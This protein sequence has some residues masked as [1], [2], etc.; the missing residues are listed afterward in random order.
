[1]K[2]Y[3]TAME[4]EKAQQIKERI[5]ALNKH[6]SKSQVVNPKITDL[7]VYSILSDQTHVM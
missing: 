7:E 6:Q 3:A 1:M 4:F 2:Q 5:E